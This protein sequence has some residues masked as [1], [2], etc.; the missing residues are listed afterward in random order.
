V[1]NCIG[2]AQAG[3]EDIS[4]GFNLRKCFLEALQGASVFVGRKGGQYQILLDT[5]D[6]SLTR[7]GASAGVNQTISSA[8]G[9]STLHPEFRRTSWNSKAPQVALG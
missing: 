8:I 6:F 4:A 9:I 7:S 1:H 2:I 3:F 5:Q